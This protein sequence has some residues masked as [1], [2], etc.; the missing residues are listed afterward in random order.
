MPPWEKYAAP[1]A[2][3]AVVAPDPSQVALRK[4]DEGRKDEDQVFQRQASQRDAL[5]T[6]LAVTGEARS[7]RQDQREERRGNYSDI[8]KMRSDYDAMPGVKEYRVAIAQVAQGLKTKPDGAGDNALVYA[9]AKAMDPGSV[10]RESETAMA[11]ATGSWLETKTAQLKKQFGIEGGGQLSDDTRASLRREMLTKVGELNRAYTA[12]RRRYTADA[13]A[14]GFDPIRVIGPH[15]GTAFLPEIQNALEKDKRILP[16]GGI[17][18]GGGDGAQRS[19]AP[20]DGGPREI[21]SAGKFANDPVLAGANA[22]VAAMIQGGRPADEVRRYLNSLRPGLADQ[23]GNID[24]AVDYARKN[25][26]AKNWLNLDLEKSW[27]PATPFMQAVGD[28]ANTVPGAFALGAADTAS[29]GTIDNLSANPE[30]QRALQTGVAYANPWSYGTGQVAGGV[31]AAVG[32]EAGAAPYAALAGDATVGAAYGAGS[33]D[34]PADSRIASALI[35]GTIGAVGG[36]VGR[37]IGARIPTALGIRRVADPLNRGERSVYNAVERTGV[38]PVAAALAKNAEVGVPAS[39]ADV[40]ADVNSLTGAAIRRS[41]VAANLARDT[42]IP[43]GRGQYD[44]FVG[45]VE[46]DLGPL[47]N[48]LE[49]SDDLIQQARTN[50]GPL[51]SEAYAAPVVSTPELSSLLETPFAR[52]GIAR[53]RTIAANERRNPEGMGFALDGNGDVVLNPI[54]H[55]ALGA[56]GAAERRVFDA[57]NGLARARSSLTGGGTAEQAEL[58]AANTALAQAREQIATQPPVGMAASSPG[59][60]TQTLDYA[61]RGMDDVLEQYRNPMTGRLDLDEAGRAQNKVLR[62]FLDEVDTI[63]PKFGEARAA[64][65]GPASEREALGLGQESLS[66]SPDALAV[67]FGSKTP[68]QQRQMQLGFRDALVKKAGELRQSTNPFESALGTPAMEQ[69]LAIMHGQ[70]TDN[71]IARLL[72]QRDLEREAAGSGNRLIGNSMTAERNIADEAFADG[73]GMGEALEIGANLALGQVPIGTAIRGLVGT[74]IRDRM[75]LGV[76]R[77]GRELAEEI[78]PLA[79]DTNTENAIARLLMLQQQNS[80]YEALAGQASAQG[81]R[82]GGVGGVGVS[83]AIASALMRD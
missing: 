31:L 78:A 17:S 58:D 28:S 41:P 8:M 23:V 34:K 63:N 77:R 48:V 16:G 75:K 83:A 56:L 7:G 11:G 36:T 59:Y 4:K 61:K 53:A 52:Q 20:N 45:A 10:V 9:Y 70:A 27:Q 30:V 38:D 55:E 66:M 68:P 60:T 82:R 71:T 15:D 79:L 76:G 12:Q 47:D 33:A 19:G 67:Q 72:L 35:G 39:L 43:R 5:R 29:M 42:L 22:R 69:R 14:F 50:A 2:G 24:Q 51:Y 13:E 73:G 32:A 46:R 80:G 62:S 64:F 49:Q 25:P 44:R 26:G 54:P 81:A 37:Q 21:T 1:Q 65:A 18:V 57:E 3:A 74:G 6:D 40:S